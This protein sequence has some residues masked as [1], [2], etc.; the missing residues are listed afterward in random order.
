ME[1]E[2][3][4]LYQ[5]SI[6]ELQPD[7]NQPRKYFDPEGLN[8]LTA[9]IKEKGVLQPILF[10]QDDGGKLL[11][12]AGERR[13]K[14]AQTAGLAALPGIC[15]DGD[16]VE[17][18]IIENLIRQDL[19]PIEEAEA[20]KNLQTVKN[21]KQEDLARVIGKAPS[22]LS[23]ILRLNDLP[24]EIKDECRTKTKCP[25]R[26][27]VEIARCGDPKKMM[28]LYRSFQKRGLTSDEVRA[29]RPREA[30]ELHERILTK[31]KKLEGALDELNLDNVPA[32]K[33]E[34]F[35]KVFMELSKIMSEK[36]GPL[37]I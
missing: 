36:L 18:S 22:T 3:G 9:S 31:M 27:L 4:K 14:A 35:R 25:R 24:Q 15:V 28:K 16:S 13:F 32:E 11:I 34:E 17:I 12:V 5:L 20:L 19:T 2:R 37:L 1:F 26:I 23:E 6:N 8:E 10:R 29:R 21:Y 30:K 33:R 7:P